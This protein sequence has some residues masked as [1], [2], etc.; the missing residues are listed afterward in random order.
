MLTGIRLQANPTP[1][2]KRV[3]S[4]WMGLLSGMPSVM[5]TAITAFLPESITL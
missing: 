3:L 5:S 2:Q 4:Q 1:H